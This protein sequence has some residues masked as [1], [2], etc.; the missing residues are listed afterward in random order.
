MCARAPEISEKFDD[1]RLRMYMFFSEK[2]IREIVNSRTKKLGVL[3]KK[4]DLSQGAGGDRAIHQY[5]PPPPAITY[6]IYGN[7]FDNRPKK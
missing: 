1:A 7:I 5:L 3:R 6:H 2:L 4:S